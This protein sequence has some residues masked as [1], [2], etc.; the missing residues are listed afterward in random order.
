VVCFHFSIMGVLCVYGGGGRLKTEK[1]S[2]GIHVVHKIDLFSSDTYISFN[3]HY[4]LASIEQ[5]A[6]DCDTQGAVGQRCSVCQPDGRQRCTLHHVRKSSLSR[7][8]SYLCGSTAFSS[9][10]SSE[11]GGGNG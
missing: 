7:F 4:S 8:K 3:W 11:L 2:A 5:V 1:K 6:G 9:F 10:F